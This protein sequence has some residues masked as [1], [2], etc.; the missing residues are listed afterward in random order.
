LQ[1]VIFDSSFLMAVVESPTTWFEDIVDSIGRFQP[2]LLSCVREELERLASGQGRRARS[3]RVALELASKFSALPCG[4]ASVDD[5]IASLAL[6]KGALVATVDSGLL[7]S[8]RA[9]HVRV[10]TLRRGR[11]SLGGLGPS[12]A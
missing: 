10:V 3:A 11:V 2:V 9:S 12:L 7:R 1:K 6:T 5:E 4:K 8:L